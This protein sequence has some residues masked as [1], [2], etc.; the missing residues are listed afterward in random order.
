M[1]LVCFNV[2]KFRGEEVD[3]SPAARGRADFIYKLQNLNKMDLTH[4]EITACLNRDY[5]NTL[6][7]ENRKK[8]QTP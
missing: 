3:C 7:L 2:D 4:E 1:P 6:C 8:N 5:F